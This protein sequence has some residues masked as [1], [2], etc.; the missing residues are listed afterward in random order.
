MNNLTGLWDIGATLLVV[1]YLT[2]GQLGWVYT[3]PECG[4]PIKKTVGVWTLL[5]L[6]KEDELPWP[7][8]I[9]KPLVVGS[10][11]FLRKRFTSLP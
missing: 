9:P 8:L 3:H 10:F 4:S 5:A 7:A 11:H 2:P 1:F 6:K